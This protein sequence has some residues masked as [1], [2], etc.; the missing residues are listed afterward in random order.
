MAHDGGQLVQTAWGALALHLPRP[1]VPGGYWVIEGRL[2]AGPYPVG[3]VSE[4]LVARGVGVFVNLTEDVRRSLADGFSHR[5]D[6][7]VEGSARLYRYPVEDFGVPT[8]AGMGE[9]LDVIDRELGAGEAVYVHCLAGLGRTGTVVGCWLV[10]HGI[11]S[12]EVLDVLLALRRQD[13]IAVR[14][15]SPQTPEQ[16]DLVLGWQVGE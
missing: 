15:Q 7:A 8:R 3:A 10:R 1:P 4:E 16:R 6:S 14:W 9:I 12:E 13:P 2:A 5:Y 11:S